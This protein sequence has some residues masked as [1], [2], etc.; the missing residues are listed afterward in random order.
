MGPT[1]VLRT[2][3]DSG[4][5]AGSVK[6]CVHALPIRAMAARWETKLEKIMFL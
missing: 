5:F 6:W 3:M 4:L 1:E 2:I